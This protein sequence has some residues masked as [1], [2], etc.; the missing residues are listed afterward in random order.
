M[1]ASRADVGF[2]VLGSD[3]GFGDDV[4]FC[5]LFA[6][7]ALAYDMAAGQSGAALDSL[8]ACVFGCELQ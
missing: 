6:V 3:Y 1:V 7:C 5:N 8:G 2:C 4:D